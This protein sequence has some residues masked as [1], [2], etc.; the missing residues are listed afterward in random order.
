[1]SFSILQK[2]GDAQK[3]ASVVDVRSGDTVKVTKKKNGTTSSIYKRI[4]VNKKTGAIT[5]KKGKLEITEA[6]DASE[7]F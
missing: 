5:F 4:I 6:P 2:I 3:K 1:M 7:S